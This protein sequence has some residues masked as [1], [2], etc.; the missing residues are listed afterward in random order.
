MNAVRTRQ[1]VV[2]TANLLLLA[3]L[4][5]NRAVVPVMLRYV[6]GV[7]VNWI[8]RAAMDVYHDLRVGCKQRF[9]CVG[10]CCLFTY[11]L[12]PKTAI[13]AASHLDVKSH[14]FG[15]SSSD[16]SIV[17]QNFKSTIA[18]KSSLN[19]QNMNKF[20]AKAMRPPQQPPK[21]AVLQQ[22]QGDPIRT[23]S[24]SAVNV[25][26]DAPAPDL[27]TP[28]DYDSSGETADDEAEIA[29]SPVA[30]AGTGGGSGVYGG[31][32]PGVGQGS[33]AATASVP[34][35]VP[36][37]TT[38]ADR[39]TTSWQP[40]RWPR[41][42]RGSSSAGAGLGV[43]EKSTGTESADLTGHRSGWGA[44]RTHAV[45]EQQDIINMPLEAREMVERSLGKYGD[46]MSLSGMSVT[47][48]Y[49]RL[50]VLQ[51]EIHRV[52]KEHPFLYESVMYA[53]VT[54]V[55]L[56][57]YTTIISG[58]VF[59]LFPMPGSESI[60]FVF[61]LVSMA[62]VSEADKILKSIKKRKKRVALVDSESI[63]KTVEKDNIEPE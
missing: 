41:W 52:L 48:R 11:H 17:D 60:V 39:W 29:A 44:M 6:R 38:G 32:A 61:S 8:R 14:G 10:S 56:I 2:A 45:D 46:P 31:V 4:K 51:E 37:R 21:Q 26:S 12:D 35:M 24:E 30:T 27:L 36:G 23:M 3:L 33:A 13:S 55:S 50:L 58:V 62:T 22:G 1:S 43:S 19:A 16:E 7:R 20:R 53:W 15:A 34:L 18:R 42:L 59:Y 54:I 63:D 47:E 40:P 57:V 5:M 49:Y 25:R 9:L 28:A